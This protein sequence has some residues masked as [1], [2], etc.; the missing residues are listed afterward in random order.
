MTRITS[1]QM[2]SLLIPH[3]IHLP[4]IPV[5]IH[6]TSYGLNAPSRRRKKTKISTFCSV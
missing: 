3:L 6:L 4:W 2:M 5:L 1:N